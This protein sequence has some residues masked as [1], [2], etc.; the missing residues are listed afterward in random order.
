MLQLCFM[1]MGVCMLDIFLFRYLI[2]W[3]SQ[4]AGLRR[5]LLGLLGLSFVTGAFTVFM[6]LV[7][8]A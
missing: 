6:V 3:R 8:G 7:V 5:W 2:R 4:R 1:C